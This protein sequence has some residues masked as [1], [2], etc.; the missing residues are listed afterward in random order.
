MLKKRIT[1][2]FSVVSVSDPA[3]C[4][5]PI[6]DINDYASSRDLSK[7][8][9]DVET[10]TVIPTGEQITVFK[11]HPL[12]R[13][14]SH[15]TD[16]DGLSQKAELIFRNHVFAAT[17]FDLKTKEDKNGNVTVR[18]STMDNIPDDVVQEIAL[19]IQQT[20]NGRGADTRPFSVPDTW[21]RDMLMSTTLDANIA[22]RK[23]AKEH[24]LKLEESQA[25][26]E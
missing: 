24:Y 20:S 3:L 11:A 21:R 10:G 19:V 25:S 6:A 22:R 14:W 17:N 1:A 15:L 2:P 13:K 4:A 26:T 12:K 16:M 7:L 9:I 23:A 18:S 5:F 8:D